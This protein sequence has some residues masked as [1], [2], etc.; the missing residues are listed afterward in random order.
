MLS[1]GA[2]RINMPAFLAFVLLALAYLLLGSA[3]TMAIGDTK[4]S[5]CAGSSRIPAPVV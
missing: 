5:G 4:R 2:Y 1:V 3:S